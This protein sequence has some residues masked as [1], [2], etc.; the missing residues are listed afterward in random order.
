M[1]GA[2]TGI[3]ECGYFLQVAIDALNRSFEILGHGRLVYDSNDGVGNSTRTIKVA[4]EVLEITGPQK[5][6]QLELGGRQ[7]KKLDL[8]SSFFI[9]A[10]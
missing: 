6:Q 9:W 2:A 5:V 4:S 3:E 10:S 7:I 8:W 1:D